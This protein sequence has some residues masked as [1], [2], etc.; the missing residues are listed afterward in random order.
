MIN[1]EVSINSTQEIKDAYQKAF[2][3]LAINDFGFFD[4]EGSR[5]NMRVLNHTHSMLGRMAHG[6]DEISNLIFGSRIFPSSYYVIDSSSVTGIVLMDESQITDAQKK[7]KGFINTKNIPAA[8]HLDMTSGQRDL[9]IALS[10]L[11]CIDV[12]PA[13]KKAV[14]KKDLYPI[15]IKQVENNQANYKNG[16]ILPVLSSELFAIA[17][18]IKEDVKEALDHVIRYAKDKQINVSREQDHSPL[19]AR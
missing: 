3:S 16:D 13:E 11:S 18:L 8:S 7:T 4:E 5:H 2:E 19:G 1:E 14:M 6:A 10:I 15:H 17:S 12:D 9:V